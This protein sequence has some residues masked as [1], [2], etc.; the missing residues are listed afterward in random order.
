LIDSDGYLAVTT[1]VGLFSLT[2]QSISANQ[3]N[4]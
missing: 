3:K 1:E 4:S 2:V